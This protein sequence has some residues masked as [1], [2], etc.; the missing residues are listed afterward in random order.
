[1][2]NRSR[3]TFLLIT[4]PL[5][6]TI[7]FLTI[8]LLIISCKPEVENKE[9][10][11]FNRFFEPLAIPKSLDEL[12]TSQTDFAFRIYHQKD[13]KEAIV[14][15]KYALIDNPNNI[16]LRLYLGI[17]FLKMGDLRQA[18][19]LFANI[20][21]H[22]KEE[23]KEIANW[24]LALTLLDDDKASAKILLSQL[25]DSKSYESLAKELY[26]LI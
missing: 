15:F 5:K 16:E 19:K 18:K 13:Y 1:M 10:M 21:D 17:S 2:R 23:Y 4:N 6:K 11:L 22:G 8:I 7:R 24:Y 25:F 26:S 14:N 12:G 9:Q 20:M 3:A